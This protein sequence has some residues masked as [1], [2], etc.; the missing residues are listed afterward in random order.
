MDSRQLTDNFAGEYFRAVGGNR[1]AL[2]G[3]LLAAKRGIGLSFVL[4]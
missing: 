1:V 3:R 4:C 2:P